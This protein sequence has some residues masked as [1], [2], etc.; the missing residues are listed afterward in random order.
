MQFINLLLA[1]MQLNY[2]S[3]WM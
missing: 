1:R 3:I 2:T